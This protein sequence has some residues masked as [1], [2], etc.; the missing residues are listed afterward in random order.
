M[1]HKIQIGTSGWNYNH[2]EGVFYP[3]GLPK[4]KW[5]PFYSQHFSTVEINATFYR[6]PKP[7]TFENWRNQTPEGFVWAVK[8]NRFITHIKRL[9]EVKD[10]LAKFFTD[11]SNLG[12]KFGPVLF[13]LPPSLMFKEDT[14]LRFLDNVVIYRHPCALEVR[15][16][17]WINERAFSI[18]EKYGVAFC[19]SDTA[20]R[21]PYA[22]VITASFVYIR[23][24]GSKKLYASSYTE[25][26]LHIWANKILEWQR[27]TY[28]F[29]DNDFGG[30]APMNASRLKEILAKKR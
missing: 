7:S 19:I 2:W 4:K 27:E 18:M 25:D 11:A 21:Y 5:L 22:E 6:Q 30:Y 26:E 8:A 28:V 9:Q 1:N 29:F 15:N 14:L 13:Q 20:G 3:P 16:K 23:L 12:E 17:S 10:P 24:H